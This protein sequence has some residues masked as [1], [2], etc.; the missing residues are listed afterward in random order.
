MDVLAIPLDMHIHVVVRGRDDLGHIPWQKHG[1]RK[2]LG[3]GIINNVCVAILP[4]KEDLTRRGWYNSSAE[5]ICYSGH[6][7]IINE[8]SSGPAMHHGRA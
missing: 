7:F 4:G 2:C 8:W 3:L 6:K 1:A 5:K